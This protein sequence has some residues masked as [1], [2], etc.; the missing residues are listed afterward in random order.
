MAYDASAGPVGAL[1]RSRPGCPDST[2]D[3][4]V[5]GGKELLGAGLVAQPLLPRQPPTHPATLSCYVIMRYHCLRGW[6]P[7]APRIAS[8][9]SSSHAAVRQPRADRARVSLG[10]EA[11]RRGHRQGSIRRDRGRSQA[12]HNAASIARVRR[13]LE[14]V[15]GASRR[16][17]VLD[18][19]AEPT[20]VSSA[21]GPPRGRESFPWFG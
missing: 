4:R 20:P 17:A 9:A 15:R 8:R 1:Q 2:V 12:W 18:R 21:H 13:G 11:R 14:E 5:R 7:I 10:S 6:S 16:C 19:R 3:G